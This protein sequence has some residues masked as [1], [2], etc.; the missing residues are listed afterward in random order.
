MA[1]LGQI[2]VVRHVPLSVSKK[3]IE[4]H[5]GLRRFSCQNNNSFIIPGLMPG[6]NNSSPCLSV[7]SNRIDFCPCYPTDT[8]LLVVPVGLS[9]AGC[10][11]CSS[12]DYLMISGM[13]PGVTMR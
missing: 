9:R 13:C 1:G 3:R 8:H 2:A 4:H 12:C 10:A 11:C 6:E 7:G 5:K